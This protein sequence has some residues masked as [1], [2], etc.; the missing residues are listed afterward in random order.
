[1]ATDRP[2]QLS[3]GQKACLRM[4]LRH[5]S[6]K[7]IARALDISPH[8]VDQR[9]KLAMRSLGAATWVDAARAFAAIEAGEGYQCLV[10]QEPDL[11]GAAD[12]APLPRS[13]TEGKAPPDDLGSRRKAGWTVLI[14][15]GAAVTVAALLVALL[16][17][18]E[19]TR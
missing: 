14:V 3:E 17:L 19:L 5:M 1:M 4:V 15:A 8:T 9:L 16:T 18:S 11:A 7:D 10:Y 2:A 12:P 6:S 13:A